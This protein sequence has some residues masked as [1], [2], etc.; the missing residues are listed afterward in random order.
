MDMVVKRFE[1]WNVE[2]NPTQGSEINKI[3]PCLI[4]S[5]NEVNKFLNTVV[6]VP[7]TTAIRPYPTRL[8]CHFKGKGGQLVVDQIR[9]I[10]KSRLI[11]KLGIMD[12]KTSKDV[13]ALI[14]ETFKYQ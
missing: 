10:D 13:C 12:V 6:I 4:V 2:L 8:D 14:I 9:S 3:R 7:M 11:G 1:V 5:P